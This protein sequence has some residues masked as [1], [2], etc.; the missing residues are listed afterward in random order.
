LFGAFSAGKSSFANAL[1]GVPLLPVSPN[2]T[3]AAINRI[4]PVATGVEGGT[5]VVRM[6][7]LER[8][9]DDVQHSLKMLGIA[10][11]SFDEALHL[12]PAISTQ[13]VSVKGR[14]HLS[15]LQAVQVGWQD[16]QPILGTQ[17]KTDLQDFGK[18]VADE[19]W[20]CFVEDVEIQHDNVMTQKRISLVDTPGA[21][22]VNARHTHISFEYIKNAD[23]ILFVT[24]YNH[25]FSQ[26]DRDFL[27]QLGRVKDRFQL[28]KM[29]FVI[30]AA[31]LASSDE[32][33]RDVCDHVRTQLAQF[34][35]HEPK[36]FPLSS[37]NGLL[38]KR[39][40]TNLTLEETGLG[41]F[42]QAFYRFIQQELSVLLSHGAEQE[43]SAS[44]QVIQHLLQLAQSDEKAKHTQLVKLRSDLQELTADIGSRKGAHLFAAL[45]REMEELVFY[46]KQRQ[47]FQ[48]GER[49]QRSF[50][51]ALLREDLRDMGQAM[52]A[53][54][55]DLLTQFQGETVRELQATGLRMEQHMYKELE[56]YI[57]RLQADIRSRWQSYLANIE[58]SSFESVPFAENFNCELDT[59]WLIKQYK[60]SRSFFAEGGSS[61]LRTLLENK[62]LASLEQFT[63]ECSERMFAHYLLAFEQ[64]WQHLIENVI[65][66]MRQYVDYAEQSHGDEMDTGLLLEC[67]EKLKRM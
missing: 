67:H 30:N 15:F 3:T 39:G 34:G 40:E 61:K 13:D 28:D 26:A 44:K 58:I 62:V 42:E 7:S 9:A 22:S 5:V 43:I 63:D 4:V 47:R 29:L 18:Y 55:F 35:I 37:Q 54:W 36:L 51:P 14:P 8:L 24:Y 19:R 46:V 20:S 11:K 10:S 48:F 21:D 52:R 23:V 65:D 1:M 27:I 64:Q 50:N 38:A 41:A 56:Q 31:D 12:I 2:P 6:K 45:R 33:L 49:Y 60:N 16:C 17:V 25:A 59:E 53:A 32:E 57:N 66:S